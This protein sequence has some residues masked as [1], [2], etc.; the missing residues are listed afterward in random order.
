MNILLVDDE[1]IMVQS[2][3]IGLE[4]KGYHVVNADSASKALNLLYG[5]GNSVDMVVTDYLMPT[6]NGMELLAAIR[7]F[8]P[9]LPVI[10][11][12]AYAETSLV[13]EA[14]K[15]HCDA[16]IE[17]PFKPEALVLEIERVM[18]YSRGILGQDFRSL[19]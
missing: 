13:I 15:N 19:S 6:M 16:F 2:I 7:R 14:L 5:D 9:S 4:M 3:K 11:M 12:T 10:I 1:S 18:W 8:R 17:K